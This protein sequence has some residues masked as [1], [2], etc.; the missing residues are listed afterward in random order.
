MVNNKKK[1]GKSI[2]TKELQTQLFCQKNISGQFS[3]NLQQF[4]TT[5]KIID[6]KKIAGPLF[7][8]CHQFVWYLI[9]NIDYTYK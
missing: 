4:G 5:F 2:L 3:C 1:S 6:D 7:I 9:I 8:F